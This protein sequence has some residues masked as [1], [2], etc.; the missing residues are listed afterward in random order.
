[1]FYSMGES[2]K[3]FI[4]RVEDIKDPEKL[5]RV[6]IRV[7]NDQTGPEFSKNLE[8]EDLLW[9]YT[10]SAIQSASLYH[11][12]ISEEGEKYP[13]PDWITAVG[14]SPTGI[15]L[16]SYVFG[17][18]VDGVEQ[19]IPIIFGTYHKMSCYPEPTEGT[20]PTPPYFND[21]AMLAQG[22]ADGQ[23]LPKEQA[24]SAK[25]TWIIEPPSPYKTEYPYNTTYTTK[26]G[27]AIELDDT[28]G[29][30]RIHIWHKSGSYDE[31]SSNKEAGIDG[32]RVVKTTDNKW[33][34]VIKDNNLLVKGN[35]NVQIDG[36]ATVKVHGNLTADIDG[37]SHIHSQGD[38]SI[39]S[40]T[41]IG[42]TAPRIDLN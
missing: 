13:V 37:T 25:Q 17:F 32:Q 31:V 11:S 3:W 22:G 41:H 16:Q 30:E 35:M 36:N 27:H 9:A 15:A 21:V 14:L 20:E 39:K 7:L 23:T 10:I 38:M 34:I 33:E 4:A 18:Y 42:L 5:G 2:F 24:K 29:Y 19:N 1:M 28:L 8:K 6:R 12:K 40:D 26:S